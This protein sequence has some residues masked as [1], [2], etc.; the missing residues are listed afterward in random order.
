MIKN[1][2]PVPV[3]DQRLHVPCEKT[4]TTCASIWWFFIDVQLHCEPRK[5]LERAQ[6]KPARVLPRRD[7][8]Y[9]I[10]I[11]N[12]AFTNKQGQI[13]YNPTE[14]QLDKI[15]EGKLYGYC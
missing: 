10:E 4:K 1:L 2:K 14:R 3:A 12:G 6:T 8:Q 15:F 5:A 7:R 13:F 9:L 11:A